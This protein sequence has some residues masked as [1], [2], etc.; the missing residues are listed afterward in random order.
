MPSLSTRL[1]LKRPLVSD[2]FVTQDLYDNLTLLDGYPG[3]FICS[4]STRP[5][6]W[7]VSQAGQRIVESDTNLAWR[8][9]GSGWVRVAPVG[10][11]GYSELTADFS[12]NA[13]SAT[14]ISPSAVAL[15]N[16]VTIPATT[17]GSTTKRIKVVAS[18]YAVDNGT[19]TTLGVA[20]VS[21]YRDGTPT[22]LFTTR[23]SGRPNTATSQLDWGNGGTIIAYDTPAVGGGSTTY[24]LRVNSL[25]A[26][27]G[28]STLRASATTRATLTVEEVG[29]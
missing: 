1:G 7:G 18:F 16:T 19:A 13:T 15:T 20:E 9:T 28:T 27:G 29:V 24:S 11:L 5:G 4:S 21:L 23:I 12:T 2:G 14:S 25:A 8:W 26:V 17:T 3:Y 10:L 22:Q 6:T